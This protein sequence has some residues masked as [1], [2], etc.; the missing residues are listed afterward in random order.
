MSVIRF[1]LE[2]TV[3]KVFG[4]NKSQCARELGMT[5]NYFS[6]LYR[7]TSEGSCSVRL[8][9]DILMLFMRKSIS[10]DDCLKE[11]FVSQRGKAIEEREAPCVKKFE[12]VQGDISKSQTEAQ[13]LT[14]LMRVATRMGD[15]LRKVF[16]ADIADCTYDCVGECPIIEFGVFIMAIKKQAGMHVNEHLLSRFEE[17][18]TKYNEIDENKNNADASA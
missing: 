2:Y 17:G 18:R 3:N 15:Q 13:D 12:L 7:R 14:D 8:V 10:L 11:Y 6:K 5:Y 1:L 4:G 16:C 9:E